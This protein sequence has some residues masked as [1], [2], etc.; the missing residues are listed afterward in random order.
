MIDTIFQALS[1]PNRRKLLETLRTGRRTA[2]E[3]SSL[4]AIS[5][6]AV[7]QHLRVL[8]DARL[9]DVEKRKT[10]RI[11]FIRKEGFADL[12]QYL[13]PFWDDHL[14]LLKTLAEDEERSRK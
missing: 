12:K 8:R 14:S 7:S 5:A 4:F 3:L 2:G 6:P 10:S 11:Y 9:I 1:D 13:D